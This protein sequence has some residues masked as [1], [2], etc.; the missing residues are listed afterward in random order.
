MLDKV[1]SLEVLE[2]RLR[3]RKICTAEGFNEM[4]DLGLVSSNQARR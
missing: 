1:R 3:A 4:P 2:T